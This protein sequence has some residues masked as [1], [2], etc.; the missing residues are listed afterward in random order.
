MSQDE[1]DTGPNDAPSRVPARAPSVGERVGTIEAMMRAGEWV[2]GKSGPVLAAAWGLSTW[3]VRQDA[4]E[5][6]RRVRA[7]LDA[8]EERI[9]ALQAIDRAEQLVEEAALDAEEADEPATRAL[10]KAKLAAE[11]RQAGSARVVIVGAGSAKRVEV[12]TRKA[13]PPAPPGWIV[14]TDG[15]EA[16]G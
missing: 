15:E 5:A 1:S 8:E 7:T 4:A 16:D 11:M 9:K 3:A 14:E 10:L 2:R 12:T 13:E 6:S